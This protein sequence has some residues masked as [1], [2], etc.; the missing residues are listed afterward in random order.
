M[1]EEVLGLPR[2]AGTQALVSK[3]GRSGGPGISWK[4]G[5]HTRT[6]W[7]GL[8]AEEDPPPGCDLASTRQRAVSSRAKPGISSLPFAFLPKKPSPELRTLTA[9]ARWTSAGLGSH[10][11]EGSPR[12]GWLFLTP[13]QGIAN[14][15]KK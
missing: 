9:C 2:L 13:P 1:P 12:L 6:R 8:T 10:G 4:Q 5:G 15:V 3:T 14:M 7:V 11:S